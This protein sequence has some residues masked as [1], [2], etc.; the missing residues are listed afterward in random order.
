MKI[1]LKIKSNQELICYEA[2]SLAM[3]LAT[4]DHQVQVW[5]T[6]PTF[7]V[8]LDPNSRLTGMVKSLELYDLPPAWLDEDVFSGWVT[9]MVDEGVASQL[10]I[11]PEGIDINDFDEVLTF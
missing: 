7:N 8:L 9:G 6:A 11:V 10:A 5:L 2:I 4:F 1:L 3:T